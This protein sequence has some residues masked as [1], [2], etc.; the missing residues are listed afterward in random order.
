MAVTYT[1]FLLPAPGKLNLHLKI[2][3]QRADG[4][5]LLQTAFQL[6]S[7]GDVISFEPAD[8]ISLNDIVDI[9]PEQNLVLRAAHRLAEVAGVTLGAKLK[10]T[11]NLP[12]GAGLGGGSSDA[13]TTLMG[14][15]LLWQLEMSREQLLQIAEPL[16]ADV[17]V[18]VF[19][20]SAWAEGIGA[21]LTPISLPLRSYLIIQPGCQISTAEIFSHPQLTRDAAPI[22]IARFLELG[23]FEND[24]EAVARRLYPEVDEAL[25][26]LNKYGPAR[27]TGT[28]SCVFIDFESRSQAKAVL[29]QVP[30]KWL[31]FVAQGLNESPLLSAVRQIQ[32]RK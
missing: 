27:M 4:Y 22:T 19:G 18:F 6:L 28:G 12:M 31:A 26:W 8:T 3:G 24:C 10:L 21:D 5:H 29:K 14:L 16:G 17:P 30:S 32:Q 11:K 1:R 2:T 13:A 15:N 20:Q 25:L 23:S 7:V 9:D